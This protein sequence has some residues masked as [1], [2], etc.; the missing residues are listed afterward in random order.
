MHWPCALAESEDGLN[1][2]PIPIDAQPTFLETYSAMEKLIGP[3]CRAIGVS[4]F[5][6]STLTT[7]LAQCNVIPVINEIEIH[8]LFPQTNL[9]PWCQEQGISILAWGPLAGGPASNY[10]QTF[11]E[12]YTNPTLR[13]LGKKYFPNYDPNQAVGAVLLSWLYTRGI[14]A[15][16]H[17]T[18]IERILENLRCLT[19]LTAEDV[20]VLNGIH[21]EL[22]GYKML[23]EG[24][25]EVLW[26]ED[27][28]GGRGRTLFG[29]TTSEIG[30]VDEKG[31]VVV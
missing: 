14:V 3:R 9:V 29:W 31:E 18:S 27:G 24:S 5:T 17:S 6:Q 20:L 26:Y 11:R 8:P 22:G 15:I 1:G 30:W 7:L 19:R 28:P 2:I 4:N 23:I 16:P 25:E 21:G 13:S 12:I 10:G